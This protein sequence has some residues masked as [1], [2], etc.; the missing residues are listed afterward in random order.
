MIST[1]ED[2]GVSVVPEVKANYTLTHLS[3]ASFLEMDYPVD[4]RVRVGDADW[5]DLLAIEQW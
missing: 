2:N 1:F 5:A 3:L 4:Q